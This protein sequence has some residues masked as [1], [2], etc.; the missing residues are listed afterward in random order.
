MRDTQHH[1]RVN[2]EMSQHGVTALPHSKPMARL[3][4]ILQGTSK[5]SDLAAWT[6]VISASVVALVIWGL[7]HAYPDALS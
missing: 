5:S 1:W 2:S 7:A 3:L 6:A 4:Q